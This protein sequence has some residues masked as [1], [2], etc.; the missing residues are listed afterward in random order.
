MSKNNEA[1]KEKKPGFWS[2][3][4]K[5]GEN[6]LPEHGPVDEQGREVLLSVKNVDIT[7]GKGDKAVKAVKT[8]V[9]YLKNSDLLEDDGQTKMKI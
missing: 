2:R 6:V 3:L 5:R 9:E 7:F 8:F 4:F 1:V